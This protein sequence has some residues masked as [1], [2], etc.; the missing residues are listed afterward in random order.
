MTYIGTGCASYETFI[1]PIIVLL[2][3]LSRQEAGTI[4]MHLD[5]LIDSF[6]LTD[7]TKLDKSLNEVIYIDTTDD[8]CRNSVFAEVS[9]VIGLNPCGFSGAVGCAVRSSTGTTDILLPER[10]FKPVDYFDWDIPRV[11]FGTC[12]DVGSSV[13]KRYET[14]VHEAGHALGIRSGRTPEDLRILSQVGPNH[15]DVQKTHHPFVTSSIL[16]SGLSRCSPSQLDVM[17]IYALYQSR[18]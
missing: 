15:A 16:N 10:V 3:G 2:E 1:D 18:D 12:L 9:S 7:F 11:A 8:D 17:A 6:D 13:P 4:R 5:G 14:V